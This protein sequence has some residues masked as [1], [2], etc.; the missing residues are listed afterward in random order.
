MTTSTITRRDAHELFPN[1]GRE[2]NLLLLAGLFFIVNAASLNTL[3]GA[4]LFAWIPVLAWCA[5]ALVGHVALNRWLPRRDGMLFPL[6][7]FLSGWGLAAIDRLAPVF[8]DRQ[9]L[10]LIVSVVAMVASACSPRLLRWL[11]RY[12]YSLL[13]GGIVLLL[14]SI[15]FGV[16]PSGQ[17]GAP[18]LWLGLGGAYFQPSEVLKLVLVAF[19]ASYLAEQYPML[20]ALDVQRTLGKGGFSPRLTGP[21]VLMWAIT[22]MVVVW[23]RDLGTALVFFLVFLALLYL[24]S[25]QTWVLWAG[26]ALMIIAGLL[27]YQLFGVVQ[28][29]VD[30]WVDPWTE[31]E[32]RGYHIVQ[33][34]MA[35]A[36]G[37]VLGQGIG[38]GAPGYVPVVHSD[39]V[40]AAIAEE[41]GFL[42]AVG[43]VALLMVFTLRGLR[44]AV[45]H[46][47]RPFYALL[48]AGL[49]A[50]IAIQSLLIMGGV[51]KLI[52]LTG[53]TL[54]FVSYGGSSLLVSFTMVGLLLRLTS[55][56]NSHAL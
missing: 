26:A 55:T 54:P 43:I 37:G 52:P 53:V 36:N 9:A 51:L 41:W 22:V 27:A 48:A 12:R 31:A 40:Y 33:S 23:Q 17:D 5:A 19:L 14:V 1:I 30:I 42:G 21:V 56:E 39:S 38:Q 46:Q 20:S 8:A 10:W 25:G 49:T 35:F 34:L 11:R 16:N 7:M 6:C 44:A 32:G 28:L 18:T 13:V 29:R 50:M 24:A 45:S 15:F 4:S 3:R 47:E 2:R